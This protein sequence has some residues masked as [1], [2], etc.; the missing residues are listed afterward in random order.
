[1]KIQN[2][3][4]ACAKYILKI[5]NAFCSCAKHIFFFE[6]AVCALAKYILKIQNDVCTCA[7]YI[8]KIQNAV[9]ALAKYIFGFSKIFIEAQNS[10]FKL[11]QANITAIIEVSK[12]S[13]LARRLIEGRVLFHKIYKEL[14]LLQLYYFCFLFCIGMIK[15]SINPTSTPLGD[16]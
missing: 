4:C 2:A 3:V 6:N 9:C 10:V 13:T 1:M 15:L 16:R 14:R 7:K 12:K 5:N 8:L 11:Q